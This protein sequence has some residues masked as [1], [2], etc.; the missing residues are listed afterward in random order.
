MKTL[1][2]KVTVASLLLATGSCFAAGALSVSREVTVDN[3]QA[4]VWKLVGN[5][6]ALDVWHP[7]VIKSE[8]KGSATKVGARRLLTL[9]DGA[10]ILESLLTYNAAKTTYSYSI[11][12]S[13][14]PIANYKATITLTPVDETHTLM[15]W[16]STFDA[17]G[18]SDEQASTIIGGIYDAGMAKVVAN[19]KK[20]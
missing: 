14:L 18:V 12:K 4:T 17:N 20:Q 15:Q 16:S 19:F 8:L 9:G 3:S 7:A 10:T 11:V 5:F 1:A 2:L 6:N 13:P